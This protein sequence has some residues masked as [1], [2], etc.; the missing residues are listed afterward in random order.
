MPKLKTMPRNERDKVLTRIA[1]L[2]AMLLLT[3]SEDVRCTIREAI[4]DCE[5]RLIA[6]NGEIARFDVRG[7]EFASG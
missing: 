5:R 1:E 3:Q 4:A 7:A 6:L 2:H